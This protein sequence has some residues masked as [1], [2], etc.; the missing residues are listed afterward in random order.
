MLGIVAVRR[1]AFDAIKNPPEN[2]LPA[3]SYRECKLAIISHNLELILALD[4]GFVTEVSLAGG[5]CHFADIKLAYITLERHD[6]LAFL[7]N[8][9]NFCCAT[10]SFYIKPY[11]VP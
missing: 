1:G 5:T 8:R 4:Q 11:R 7:D 3:P 2:E 10:V 9:G 6:N